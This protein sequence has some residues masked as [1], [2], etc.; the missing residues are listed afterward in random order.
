MLYNIKNIR[1]QKNMTQEELAKKANISRATVIKLERGE[2]MEVKV[3][4]LEALAAA[5]NCSVSAFFVQ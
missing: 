3:S 1:Q 5:L 4:T 2:R